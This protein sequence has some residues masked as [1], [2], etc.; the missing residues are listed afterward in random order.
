MRVPGGGVGK[1]SLR[2]CR[3]AVK[4]RRPRSSVGLGEGYGKLFPRCNFLPVD[5][6]NSS[7]LLLDSRARDWKDQRDR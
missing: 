2:A 1:P 4:P 7:R 5:L 3:K 6:L